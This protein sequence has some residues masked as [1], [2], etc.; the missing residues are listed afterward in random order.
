M[1][2]M[3]YH[4]MVTCTRRACRYSPAYPLVCNG[5]VVKEDSYDAV[6][7]LLTWL[8]DGPWEQLSKA[9][10]QRAWQAAEESDAELVAEQ[11]EYYA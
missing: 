11:A 3:M 8:W 10:V 7:L 9:S 1:P 2:C 4:N 5:N 6:R